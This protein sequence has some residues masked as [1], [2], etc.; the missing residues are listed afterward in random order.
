ML[1]A[2]HM[3][4]AGIGRA[5]ILSMSSPTIERTQLEYQARR[6]HHVELAFFEK[7]SELVR[8][9]ILLARDDLT[10]T[11]ASFP[12]LVLNRMGLLNVGQDGMHAWSAFF[13]D[14]SEAKPS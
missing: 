9:A 4:A 7:A 13:S 12:R 3:A 10:L 8:L 2:Q 11:L 6:L 14:T 1:L 5:F